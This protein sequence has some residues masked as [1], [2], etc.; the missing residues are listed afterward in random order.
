MISLTGFFNQRIPNNK[1]P[2]PVNPRTSPPIFSQGLDSSDSKVYNPSM[3]LTTPIFATLKINVASLE[4]AVI[5]FF[6]FSLF[7]GLPNHFKAGIIIAILISPPNA[8]RR[9]SRKLGVLN[10]PTIPPPVF[11]FCFCTL[12]YSASNCFLVAFEASS[13]ASCTFFTSLRIL[14][15]EFKVAPILLT[16]T[17]FLLILFTRF[18]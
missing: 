7:A 3:V 9:P 4:R 18:P 1:V 5:I 14:A 10:A 13:C 15:T 12:V 11:F 16:A 8:L 17:V 6:T 2:I